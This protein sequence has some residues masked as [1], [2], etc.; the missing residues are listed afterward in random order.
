[1]HSKVTVVCDDR[2]HF[3]RIVNAIEKAGYRACEWS[4]DSAALA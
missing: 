1:L 2:L 3:S 4:E